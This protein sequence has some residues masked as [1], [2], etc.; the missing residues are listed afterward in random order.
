MPERLLVEPGR[1][2]FKDIV[3]VEDWATL[4]GEHQPVFDAI[5]DRDPKRARLA[6]IRQ[7]DNLRERIA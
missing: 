7:F 5:C 2:G 4:Q 3:S 1:V 6:M